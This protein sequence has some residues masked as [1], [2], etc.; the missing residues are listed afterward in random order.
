MKRSRSVEEKDFERI[1]PRPPP[2]DVHQFL[3]A[4]FDARA[5]VLQKFLAEDGTIVGSK[6]PAAQNVISYSN[7]FEKHSCPACQGIVFEP[8]EK[9]LSNEYLWIFELPQDLVDAV[10]LAACGCSWFEWLVDQ[11]IRSTC[12]PS[13]FVHARFQLEFESQAD[14][15]TD[16][17]HVQ[18][19]A[20]LGDSQWNTW[21][22]G[23]YSVHVEAGE[24]YPLL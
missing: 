14:S 16:I 20:K 21:K 8:E 1:R 12:P 10:N 22:L 13:Q 3:E 17:E 15:Y 2:E 11:L 18:V 4:Y 24:R 19:V 7:S 6:L 23:S 9:Q 5:P